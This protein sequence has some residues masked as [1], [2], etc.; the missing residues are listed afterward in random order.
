MKQW[1]SDVEQ[2]AAQ[3]NVLWKKGNEE[4]SAFAKLKSQSSEW[5]EDKMVR[6]CKATY[7][8][9]SSC[10]N[11]KLQRSPQGLSIHLGICILAYCVQIHIQTYMRIYVWDGV[12]G[13][14]VIERS[15]WNNF[16]SLHRARNSLCAQK[17]ESKAFYHIEHQVWSLKVYCLSSGTKLAL[18]KRLNWTHLNK[19]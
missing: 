15:M 6:L 9:G 2:Q 8:T 18:D 10:I 17:A 14:N 16:Q 12:G 7:P 19:V 1:F 4:S 11:R 3:N 13:G 5:R